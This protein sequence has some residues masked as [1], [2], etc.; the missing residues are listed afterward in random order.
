LIAGET[1]EVL[2]GYMP[3]SSLAS[4][5][6]IAPQVVSR[7]EDA[8]SETPSPTIGVQS[9]CPA[10]FYETGSSSSSYR[11]P[12]PTAAVVNNYWDEFAEA[13]DPAHIASL[14]GD[15][16]TCLSSAAEKIKAHPYHLLNG[17]Y[18]VSALL[19]EP[20][21]FRMMQALSN[22]Y[23][24]RRADQ[25]PLLAA[26]LVRQ[27]YEDYRSAING[28]REATLARY[29]ELQR[30]Y[31]DARR[32]EEERYRQDRRNT[33]I[34]AVIGGILLDKYAD[35]PPEIVAETMS[36]MVSRADSYH[37]LMVTQVERQASAAE[38]FLTGASDM[39]NPSTWTDDGVRLHVVRFDGPGNIHGPAQPRHDHTRYIVRIQNSGFCTGAIVGPRL[40]LTAQHCIL[41]K[42]GLSKGATEV[43]WEYFQYDRS[44]GVRYTV[45]SAHVTRWTTPNQKWADTWTADWALLELDKPIEKEMGYLTLLR[46]DQDAAQPASVT[47][48]GYSSDIDK[49]EYITMDWGCATRRPEGSLLIH[50]CKMW[51]GASGAPVIVSDGRYKGRIVAVN[52]FGR[53]P[54]A[55]YGGGPQSALF[56]DTWR[57]LLDQQSSAD[58]ERK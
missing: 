3:T 31:Q 6:G 35:A 57:T 39:G 58:E 46:L 40:V 14:A 51:K 45:K 54:D 26:Q 47:V 2:G 17:G 50:A 36:N 37:D 12:Y 16:G 24:P 48:A 27:T 32:K 49:G 29:E 42:D 15:F 53:G 4:A 43:R 18:Q 20:A 23:P 10:A 11:F 5:L 19:L 13:N 28:A 1:F 55:R 25:N 38:A 41:D 33:M 21:R 34:G 56:F 30:E 22:L 52:A 44:G 7:I 9:K 8:E